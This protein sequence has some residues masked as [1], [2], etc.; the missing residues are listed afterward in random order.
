MGQISIILFCMEYIFKIMNLRFVNPI[1]I[2][3]LSFSLFQYLFRYYFSI[4][5]VPHLYKLLTGIM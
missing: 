2:I 3:F 4:Y 5:L 1:S